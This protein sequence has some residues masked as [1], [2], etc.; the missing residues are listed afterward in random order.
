MGA[1]VA[2]IGNVDRWYADLYGVMSMA[3]RLSAII[4]DR[5]TTV[6]IAYR[7]RHLDSVL[8]KMFKDIHAG[9]N[10]NAKPE[11]VSPK[12]V[13]ETIQVLE[14][15][16]GVLAKLLHVCKLARLTNNSLMAQSLHNIANWNEEVAELIEVIQISLNRELTDSLYKRSKEERERGEIFDLSEV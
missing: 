9:I 16:H 5:A 10:K 8:A 13:E 6:K 1:S 3:Y 12:Q 14:K 4:K 7:L 2:V 15:L 11:V